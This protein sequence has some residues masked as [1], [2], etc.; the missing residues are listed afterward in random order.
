MVRS[1][2][3]DRPGGSPPLGS[4]VESASS[5]GIGRRHTL[6]GGTDLTLDDHPDPPHDRCGFGEHN[7]PDSAGDTPQIRSAPLSPEEPYYLVAEVEEEPYYLVAE[8]EWD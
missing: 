1:A 2:Y 6:S 5:V 4:N 8:V 3:T 7:A